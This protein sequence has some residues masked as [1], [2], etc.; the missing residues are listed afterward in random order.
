MLNVQDVKASVAGREWNIIW[1][2]AFE[3][4]SEIIPILQL[5]C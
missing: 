4:S 3:M 2:S 5:E 1:A